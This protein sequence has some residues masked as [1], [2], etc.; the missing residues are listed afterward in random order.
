MERKLVSLRLDVRALYALKGFMPCF[1]YWKKH[2]LLCAIV[3]NVLLS[4]DYQNLDKL[5]HWSPFGVKKLIITIEE[6]DL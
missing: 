4:I 3:T 5:I 2:A 6:Q 1:R